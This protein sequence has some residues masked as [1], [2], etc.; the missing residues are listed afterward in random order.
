MKKQFL[1]LNKKERLGVQCSLTNEGYNG[2]VSQEPYLLGLLKRIV[3][4]FLAVLTTTTSTRATLKLYS[5]EHNK[6][7]NAASFRC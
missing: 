1:I 2:L 4:T 5:N 6:N 3:F 7:N